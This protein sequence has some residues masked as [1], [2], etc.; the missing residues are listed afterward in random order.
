MSDQRALMR[1]DA[2]KK[3]LVIAYLLWFF[4][5]YGGVHRLYL[6]RWVSGLIMLAIF[7]VSMLLTFVFI[8]YIGVAF[9]FLWWLLDALLTAAM[10]Q[11]HNRRLAWELSR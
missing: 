11:S 1:Y 4:L 5:G 9:I 2:E 7:G 3:S 8:G 6:G 10:V